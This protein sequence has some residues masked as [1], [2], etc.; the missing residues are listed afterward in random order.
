MKTQI[1]L[2]MLL[3]LLSVTTM[4]QTQQWAMTWNGTGDFSDR[5]TCTAA[6]AQG[7]IFTAGS[8]VNIGTG[9]DFLLQKFSNSGTEI[10]RREFNDAGDGPDEVLAM[11]TDS[12]GNVYVTGFGKSADAG[13]DYL[14]QKYNASGV[15]QWTKT[16][17]DVLSNEY[18]QPNSIA[19]DHSGN[20]IV[21]GQ[22]DSDPSAISNDDYLTI[23]YSA[24]GNFLWE[25]RYNG[26]GNGTDRA[27]K[28]VVDGSNNIYVTGRSYNGVDDDYVT[29]KYNTAGVQ[30]WLKYGDQNNNDRALAMTI[31]NAANIYV[32]GRSSNGNNDDYF[33][34]KYNSSGTEVWT[35]E[36]DNV[37][38]D[39]ANAIAVDNSG[40]V[41]VTG[42]SD[43]DASAFTNYNFTTIKYNAAGTQQWVKT[44]EGAG[45]NDD[46]A[47]SI[48]IASN[49]NIIVAGS[50]DRDASP[51][52]N[53]DIG[54]LRYN[55]AGTLLWTQTYNGTGNFN[56]DGNGICA[57][58]N[59]NVFVVGRTDNA[60]EQSNAVL[61][62]YNSSGVQSFA[63][64]FDGIGDN[65]DNIREIKTDGA[66]NVYA[67]GY[68]VGNGSNRNFTLLKINASG[69]LSWMKYVDGS[70]PDSDDEANAL[71]MDNQGNIIVSGFTKNKGTSGDFTVVKYNA[72][73][74]SLWMRT[75]DAPA[76]NNDKGYDL[77]LDATGNI[78]VT[79]RVDTD[80]TINSNDDA[81]T[82]KYD[83]NGNLVWVKTFNGTGNNADRGSFIQ[84]AQSGNVYVGGRTFNGTDIDFLVIK[85]NSA[86]NQQ[87][88]K[89]FDGTFGDDVPAAME[90]NAAEDIY[91]T[92][93]SAGVT[94]SSDYMTV[95]Y[96]AAGSLLWS[97]RFNNSNGNDAATAL[98]LKNDGTCIVTGYSDADA[99]AAINFDEVD[100]AYDANGNEQW[101]KLNPTIKD[102]IGDAVLANNIQHTFFAGHI[103]A[104]NS[105]SVNFDISLSAFDSLSTPYWN[106][107]FSNPTTDSLDVPNVMWSSDSS[108][109]VGGSTWKAN[110]QRDV[111]L[112]K[113]SGFYVG[114]N[115]LL[116]QNFEVSIANP[117]NNYLSV[118]ISGT[119]HSAYSFK[120]FDATGKL[121]SETQLPSNG[122]YRIS[123]P[124]LSSG[125][126]FASIATENS[127][128]KTFKLFH[129][130]F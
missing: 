7:N 15:L 63:K 121:I 84:V 26:L 105:P 88:V 24:N 90:I 96:S 33:T 62:K 103:D 6:D 68:S 106:S 127:T 36:F 119:N 129:S 34:I 47:T 58:A 115:D 21:T 111:L 61:L 23:K 11:M 20:V 44:F 87:W 39:R 9:R 80:P 43:A 56:D 85:Y 97:K 42:Q 108:L 100:I 10:W 112:I 31:D 70:S 40:N 86:G 128:V 45:G 109:Y 29:I 104:G 110:N 53:N 125:I 57:D 81:N 60:S 37:E 18:D 32:T 123:V 67:A 95:K 82:I 12:L 83:A 124:T 126:Y 25:K 89:T 102:E 73:G 74:D 48:V 64:I 27:V 65:S 118:N 52:S 79:G 8:T 66:G 69:I 92:G 98:A 59:G 99:S 30:Q 76:H 46:V 93:F 54:V 16:Y 117:F 3:L 2:F 122:N 71:E 51:V 113:Y 101:I 4:A 116:Q 75:Y 13:D 14:T 22:S 130:N 55:A 94:D 107:N 19:I 72:N 38:H 17:N 120:L 114:T 1:S 49:G 77:T 28:C 5:Y 78:Y 35:K 91:L 50:S 41:Y